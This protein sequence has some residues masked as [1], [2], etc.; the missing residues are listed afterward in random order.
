MPEAIVTFSPAAVNVKPP[1]ILKPL[2]PGLAVTV[3]SPLIT[4]SCP[5]KTKLPAVVLTVVFTSIVTTS[6]TPVKVVGA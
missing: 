3:K 6:V 2:A 1:P 4:K 5:A